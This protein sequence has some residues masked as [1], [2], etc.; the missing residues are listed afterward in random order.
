MEF[1]VTITTVG[2]MLLYS[3]PG[4]LLVKAKKIDPSAIS[5]FAT[6]LMYICQSCLV[7]YSFQK[8]QYT[9]ALFLN[10]LTFFALAVFLQ[11]ALLGT[12]YMLFRKKYSDVR[13][14]IA[15]I[16][17]TFG[18]CAFMGVPLLE[19]LLPDYPNAVVFSAVYSIS[20]NLLGWTIASAIIANDPGY[21]KPKNFFLNPS[22]IALYIALPLFFTHTYIGGNVFGDAVFLLG[23]MTTPLCMLIM[24]MR[25]ACVPLRKIVTSRLN[26]FVLVMKQIAMPVF[27]LFLLFFLPLET[28]MKMTFYIICCCPVASVVL[29]YSELI[30]EGQDTAANLVLFGTFSSILTIPVMMT[31]SRFIK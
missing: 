29:N 11:A 21:I 14:R 15:T 26:Y 25:L 28:D 8:V 18:N 19:H 3:A 30:G 16:A 17:C 27:G 23:K 9:P 13:R 10:M 22:M 1:L 5:A 24:G 4:F 12:Y 31:L 2:V 20:M 7:V 6:V